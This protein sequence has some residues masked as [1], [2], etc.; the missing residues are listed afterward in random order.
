MINFAQ[1]QYLFLIFLI[2]VFFIVQAVLLRLRRRR[3]R[4]FGDEQLVNQKAR[5]GYV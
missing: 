3:I 4:K 2:P 1:A 5:F